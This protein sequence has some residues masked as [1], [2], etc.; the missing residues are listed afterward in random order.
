MSFAVVNPEDP[1]EIE[2]LTLLRTPVYE[3]LLPAEERGVSVS[4]ERYIE[5]E[6]DLLEEVRWNEKSAVLE[7]KTQL[8]N[9]ELDLRKVDKKSF[10]AM[11]K[12][13]GKMNHNGCVRMSGV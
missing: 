13:L 8:R 3:C 11:R 9:Y 6:H 2:G 4:F 1:T 7:L 5:D 12:V 10:L